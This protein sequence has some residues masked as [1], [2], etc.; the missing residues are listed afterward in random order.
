MVVKINIKIRG[1]LTGSGLWT[2]MATL[3]R[4][5]SWKVALALMLMV[6]VGLM[7]GIGLLLLVPL[8]QIVGLD[9]KGGSLDQIAQFISSVFGFAGI[10]PTLVTVLATY[11]LIVIVRGSLHRW[12]V[13]V[14]SGLGHLFVAYM[15]DRLYRAIKDAN[16]VFFSRSRSSDFVHLLTVETYR[17]GE[18]TH[19]LLSLLATAIIALVYILAALKLSAAMTVVVLASGGG[20]ILALRGKV[21]TARRVGQELSETVKRL[22]SVVTEHLGGMKMAKSYGTED[23]HADIFSSLTTQVRHVH[24]RAVSNQ[25]GAKFWY[26]VGSILALAVILYVSLELL[27]I[28]GTEVLL[29]ILL[30]ARLMPRFSHLQQSYQAF[31]N[32]LPAF[33]A[34]SPMLSNCEAAAEPTPLTNRNV[35]LREAIRIQGVSFSY[36]HH[37]VLENLELTIWAG[38]TTAIVGPSGS[39]KSTVA[40]L[41][42]GLIEPD[43]GQVMI[44]GISLGPDRLRAWRDQIGYVTQETFLFHDTIRANLLWARPDATEEDIRLALRQASAEELAENLPEG[45]DTVVGDRGMK[46]SG[47]ER[48]RL[49][50]ARALLRRPSLLILDEATSALDYDNEWR[51]QQALEEIH[52][53]TTI[54]IISHRLSTVQRADVINVL[55]EGRIIESGTWHALLT[56]PNG[57]FRMLIDAQSVEHE[58]L[59]RDAEKNTSFLPHLDRDRTISSKR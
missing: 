41:I 39:G 49:A 57:R 17:I 42:I 59:S 38:K 27:A 22:Y 32:R 52:G 14:S 26:D 1:L 31:V 29:I 24:A 45:L 35:V 54:L 40:D 21:G 43:E 56:K 5:A 33:N 37:Q 13:S 44:D 58:Q 9:V 3:V 20:L 46:L 6:A 51:I 53:H 7:E 18:A 15:R 36:N 19:V 4:V 50:L 8:L 16:W 23:H 47:G 48:Q 30:F 34:V 10:T 28:N 11:V 55:D 25:A 2:Y 12:Q